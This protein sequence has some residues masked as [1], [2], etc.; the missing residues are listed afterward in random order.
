MQKNKSK[1]GLSGPPALVLLISF[2]MIVPTFLNF[3][4]MDKPG[5]GYVAIIALHIIIFGFPAAFYCYIKGKGFAKR[6]KLSPKKKK[7]LAIG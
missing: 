3:G 1:G 5:A 2:L 7:I 4:S 6:I